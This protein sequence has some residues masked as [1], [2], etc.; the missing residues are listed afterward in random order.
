MHG[1]RRLILFVAAST[2][3][4]GV[5]T[6]SAPVFAASQ[7][8]LLYDFCSAKGRCKDGN[9]PLA[10]LIFDA[11]GNLYSTTSLGGAYGGGTVFQLTPGTKGTWKERVL[12]NFGQGKDGLGPLAGLVFDAAGNLYGT[13]AGGGAYRGGTVFQMTPGVKGEW[14]ERVLHS[15][16]KKDGLEPS[17]GLIFDAAGALYGTTASGG[18]PATGCGCCGCGTVFQMTPGAKGRWTEKVLH[19]FGKGSEGGGA[20]ASLIFDAAGN[21]YGTTQLGGNSDCYQQGYDVGC[22]TVFQLAQQ[23]DGTWA[24]TVLH[25]FSN[26]GVDGIYP[27]ACLIFD[28]TGNLYGTTFYGGASG[29][30]CN[31]YGCGTVFE[32]SPGANGTWTETLLYS[33][34]S[35]S[36]CADGAYPAAGLIFDTTGNLYSTT[37]EGGA[38]FGTAFQLAP[39]ANGTWT[40]TMLHSFNGDGSD[41]VNPSASMT[42]DAAGNLYGTTASGPDIDTGCNGYPCGTVFEITP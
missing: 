18:I 6:K 10:S 31:G 23:G 38:R 17:G 25:Y 1:K 34:C 28:A 42:F 12:H 11:A 20:Y 40:E 41:G 39:G 26:N 36:G 22:G 19:Y 8:R 33:F 32:L 15:F 14:K 3:V 37:L 9:D 7:E 21:L 5:L 2:V 4:F 30:G 27:L 24:E 16:R 35:A 13:T 29:T